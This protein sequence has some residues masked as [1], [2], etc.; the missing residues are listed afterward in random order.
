MRLPPLFHYICG[1]I[2]LCWTGSAPAEN[3]RLVKDINT[4]V[5]QFGYARQFVQAGDRFYFS[6]AD[7]THG[8]E[9]WVSD[10]TENG[11]HMIQDT[12]PGSIS[13]CGE[14]LATLGNTILFSGGTP[15]TGSELWRSDGTPSGTVLVKDIYPGATGSNISSESPYPVFGGSMYFVA[16]DGVHGRQLWKSDGTE[17]GTHR[18]AAS[19]VFD[20]PPHFVVA[21]DTLYFK[22]AYK[23]QANRLWR[24]DGTE[25][26]TVL[27]KDTLPSGAGLA[28]SAPLIAV[29]NTIYFQADGS[30]TGVELWKSDGTGPGTVLVKDIRPGAAGSMPCPVLAKDGLLY[31]TADDGVHGNEIWTTDGTEAGT[32]LLKDLRPGTD[33]SYVGSMA[34]LGGMVYFAAYATPNTVRLWQTDGTTDGTVPALP[35]SVSTGYTSAMRKLGD[36]IYFEVDTEYKHFALRAFDGTTITNLRESTNGFQSDFIFFGGGIYFGETEPNHGTKLMR[37]HADLSAPVEV[38]NLLGGTARGPFGEIRTLGGKAIFLAQDAQGTGLWSSDGT[39]AGTGPLQRLSPYWDHG[40]TFFSQAGSQLFFPAAPVDAVNHIQLWKTDGT[41]AGTSIVKDVNPG[42]NMAALGNTIYFR[43]YV[44]GSGYGFWKSDGTE[45]GTVLVKSV[46]PSSIVAAGGRIYFGV[47]SAVS[48]NSQLWQSDG[49]TAGTVP[50]EDGSGAIDVG[51]AEGVVYFT[52]N[53]EPGR[54]ELRRTTGGVGQSEWVATFPTGVY[55]HP[56]VSSGAAFYFEAAAEDSSTQL[57]CAQNGVPGVV[58]LT[59]SH[60]EDNFFYASNSIALGNGRVMFASSDEHGQELWLS[61]G[62]MA[63]THL[64]RDICPG[65]LSSSPEEF[66]LVNGKVYFSAYHPATG[67]ELWVSDGTAEGTTLV[68][69]LTGDSGSSSPQ[70]LRGVGD[71]LFFT[72]TTEAYGEELYV[73]DTSRGGGH[74]PPVVTLAGANPLTVEAAAAYTD[75]GASA[76]DNRQQAIP[77]VMI[78]NTVESAMPGSYAVTWTAVDG[79]GFSNS[80][81]RVVQVVDTTAPVMAPLAAVTVQATSAAGATVNYPPAQATDVVGVETITYSQETGTIFPMG[82]TTVTVTATDAAGNVATGSF[83]VIVLPAGLD[84]RGPVVTLTSPTAR[85]VS[86]GFAIAGTV[87]DDEALASLTVQLNG[88]PLPLD[89]PLPGNTNA[90]IPWSVSGGQPENGLNTIEVV[91]VDFAGFTTRV[92]RTVEYVNERPGLAGSYAVLLRPTGAGRL[93]IAEVDT[94]GLL[95]VTVTSGGAFTGRMMLAGSSTGLVGLIDNAGV[96]HFKPTGATELLLVKRTARGFVPGYLSFSLN[97]TTG[98]TATLASPAY[99]DP[100]VAAGQGVKTIFGPLHSVP[101]ELLNL[102]TTGTATR[103]LYA[104]VFPSKAQTPSRPAATYPQGAGGVSLRLAKTG[105]ITLMGN[106]ADGSVFNAAGKLRADGTAAF[107]APLYGQTGFAGGELTFA[108]D[109]DTDVKGSDWQWFR[110]GMDRA[111]Q[112]HFGWSRV[113]FDPKG[114]KYSGVDSVSF[115]QGSAGQAHLTFAEGQL[116]ADVVKA[117]R[118]DPGTGMARKETGDRTF[119][120]NFVSATGFYGGAFVHEDGCWAS[121]RG[122]LL[123]KGANQG[124]FGY[125]VESPAIS[126]GQAGGASLRP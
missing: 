65:A 108:D 62:T 121:Y 30:G 42:L 11:T 112:Y 14:I 59:S 70:N 22:T 92:V 17:A 118:V 50:I 25:A 32:K 90:A 95:Q 2:L 111:P 26:G 46:V 51:A 86:A 97:E 37:A 88:A 13:G 8:Q 94:N 96:A 31:F 83:A 34:E 115:G 33:S 73:Y 58:Q 84:R 38:K 100:P 52:K 53:G 64:V 119:T 24:T 110:P 27:V 101:A 81:T 66:A 99:G 57:F 35:G 10:G 47:Y 87:Q 120:F 104:L 55:F 45:A 69:D 5:S 48:G 105:D 19:P 72:A 61:D 15:E 102:P 16:D 93:G 122:I 125:F 109:A 6:F 41:A 1:I 71:Q 44:S 39:E 89:A 117:V 60:A 7:A 4:A 76:V 91:A 103:G 21:G 126:G 54:T 78:R 18:I 43:G 77:P 36:R 63:G 113:T 80:A 23:T 28:G 29:G 9:L 106:L 20:Y 75:P 68:A 12:A 123:H 67:A 98:V 114:T 85:K 74:L 82:R 116:S 107:F 40:V 124:G 56:V 79:L 3:P 49:T